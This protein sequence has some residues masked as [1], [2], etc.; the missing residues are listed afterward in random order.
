M[1]E[2]L[3]PPIKITDPASPTRCQGITSNGQCI[4]ESVD[5]TTRCSLHGANMQLKSIE[6]KSLKNYRLT[7]FNAQVQRMSNTS[8]LK[9]LSEEI[10]ILRVIME[11]KLNQCTDVTELMMQS[12]TISDLA[13]KIEKMV[14][15]CSK[16][17]STLGQTMDKAALLSFGSKVIQII[18]ENI[19]DPDVLDTIGTS[20]VNL[21]GEQDNG[22]N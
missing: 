2:N 6:E 20:I 10:G 18:G 5:S 19:T 16:L 8:G 21:L 14:V 17:E 22:E 7:K 15:S 9:T 3:T 4:N 11:E 1:Y 12:H 13:M